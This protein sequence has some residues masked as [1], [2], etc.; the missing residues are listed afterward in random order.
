MWKPTKAGRAGQLE[1]ICRLT[2]ASQGG[3]RL[4]AAPSLIWH[5]RGVLEGRTGRS[6]WAAAFHP[7]SVRL[8]SPSRFLSADGDARLPGFW[9][10][11]ATDDEDVPT[12]IR[13]RL[14]CTG[15]SSGDNT[16]LPEGQAEAQPEPQPE[17]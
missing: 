14:S 12:A 3:P 15:L 5:W 16:V 6:L 10:V 2:E 4:E 7:G 13:W 9:S 1:R 11:D 8:L 17:P